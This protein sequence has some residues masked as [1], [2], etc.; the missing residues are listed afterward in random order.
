MDVRRHLSRSQDISTKASVLFQ[1]RAKGAQQRFAE[2][3]QKA[4]DENIGA[5]LAHPAAAASIW[6]DWC[7]YAV[8]TVQ[9]AI[10]FWDTIRQRGNNFV[11]H[12]QPVSPRAALRDETV[13][14]R[15]FPRQLPCAHRPARRRHRRSETRL[16][17][18]STPC[19]PWPG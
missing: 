6:P 8:D 9:R 17:V 11:E 3:L 18:S 12:T 7:S 13:G 14:W 16:Y 4:I 2:Q 5:A 19:G 1:K 15:E 10:L